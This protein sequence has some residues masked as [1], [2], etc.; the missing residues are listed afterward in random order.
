MPC[1]TVH[2]CACVCAA[3]VNDLRSLFTAY[4]E[5]LQSMT[6][7]D[8]EALMIR[9]LQ[10]TD[11]LDNSISLQRVGGAAGGVWGWCWGAT[12]MW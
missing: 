4:L 1:D 2:D 9:A 12:Y 10:A 5:Q 11:L 3:Q 6:G 8:M 7:A